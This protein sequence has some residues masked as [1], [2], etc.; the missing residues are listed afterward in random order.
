[1][2]GARGR[3]GVI[4]R[5]RDCNS[6]NTIVRSA[7][8]EHSAMQMFDLVENVE[9]YA[10][11]LPWCTSS[12]VL[13][14][15]EVCTDGIP[16]GRTVAML[17]VGV[18]GIR[19]SFTTDNRNRPGESIELRLL[20]GPF[21]KFSAD[22]RFHPLGEQAAKIEFSMSY[23]I[24]S[25]LIGKVLEPLFDHIANTMVDAFIRRARAVYGPHQG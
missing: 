3:G 23:E 11:F 10:E 13:E 18:K 15:S 2:A 21:S 1:M 20:E 5:G 19:Q 17:T 14:R 25:R 22:W 24:S 7:L 4:R 12:K 8:V 6:M 9:A 16:E